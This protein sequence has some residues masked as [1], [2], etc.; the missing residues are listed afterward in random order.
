MALFRRKEK[1]VAPPAEDAIDSRLPQG[2]LEELMQEM[3]VQE[4]RAKRR[5]LA[6]HLKNVARAHLE[7]I[8]RPGGVE[9]VKAAADF[10]ELGSTRDYL[11]GLSNVEIEVGEQYGIG[12]TIASTWTVRGDHTGPI[13][14]VPPSGQRVEIT[15]VS[16]DVFREGIITTEYSYW[17]FGPVQDRL[18]GV[19]AAG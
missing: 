14:G 6:E 17:T 4:F 9:A 10:M 8:H 7:A 2:T 15:G 11:D 12:N 3:I 19:P 5:S 16:L 13:V 18:R 1:Q